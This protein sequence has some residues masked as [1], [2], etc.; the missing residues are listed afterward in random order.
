MNKIDIETNAYSRLV[1]TLLTIIALITLT[2]FCTETNIVVNARGYTK[3]TGPQQHIVANLSG[4][5]NLNKIR[6]GQYINKG[7]SLLKIT[8]SDVNSESQIIKERIKN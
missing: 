4:T 1:Y 7:Q 2:F 8:S 6:N 5:I 3:S